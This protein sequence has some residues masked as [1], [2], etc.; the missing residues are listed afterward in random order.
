[1]PIVPRAV[2][3]EACVDEANAP[4]SHLDR[5]SY[6]HQTL[7]M[8]GEATSVSPVAST[9]PVEYS[10]VNVFAGLTWQLARV[11]PAAIDVLIPVM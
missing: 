10:E 2:L 7:P 11:P 1:M 9:L 5:P 4:L 6:A 3:A 8:T